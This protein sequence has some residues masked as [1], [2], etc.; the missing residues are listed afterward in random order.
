MYDYF[1]LA[2]WEP[3]NILFPNVGLGMS[4]LGFLIMFFTKAQVLQ[5]ISFVV[6]FTLFHAR[7]NSVVCRRQTS[8]AVIHQCYYNHFERNS[9]TDK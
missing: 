2:I 4:C 3:F 1:M 5:F 9:K 8:E 7:I 6:H